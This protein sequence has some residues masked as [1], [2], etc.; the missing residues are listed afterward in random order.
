MLKVPQAVN[1]FLP[2]PSHC[3]GVFV[4]TLS[5]SAVQVGQNKHALVEDYQVG[6]EDEEKEKRKGKEER[7]GGG[8]RGEAAA[9]TAAT[10]TKERA[11][12]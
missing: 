5:Y 6:R 11:G 7:G 2:H 8:G 4:R 1:C 9:A 3:L 12:S 10:I